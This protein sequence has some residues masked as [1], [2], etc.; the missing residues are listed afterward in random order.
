MTARKLRLKGQLGC[1]R[2]ATGDRWQTGEQLLTEEGEASV[3]VMNF[4]ES[5]STPIHPSPACDQALPCLSVSEFQ[6]E[7]M[8][9]INL[10]L[11][12]ISFELD[13]EDTLLGK[14]PS[15][16]WSSLEPTA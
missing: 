6:E 9:A 15:C 3:L 11:S 12:P 8:N 10:P 7:G 14:C 16:L 1:L 2:K 4:V 5:S 13:P